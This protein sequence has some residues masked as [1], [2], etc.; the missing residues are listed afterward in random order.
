M[1]GDRASGVDDT[2]RALLRGRWLRERGPG[3]MAATGPELAV[4]SQPDCLPWNGVV[5]MSCV[6]ACD[7]DAIPLDQRSRPRVDVETCTGC[8]DCI[9]VCPTEALSMAPA[10]IARAS[11]S[12]ALDHPG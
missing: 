12:H 3:A 2:R 1:T 6:T 8:A 4:L 7:D 5:C 9:V 11:A 10:A